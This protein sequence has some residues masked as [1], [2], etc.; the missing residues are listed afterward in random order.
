[1]FSAHKSQFY[2]KVSY[3]L[4][5]ILC[6]NILCTFLEDFS[7]NL[8]QLITFLAYN[9][10]FKH[11][12]LMCHPN[13]HGF[14]SGKPIGHSLVKACQ[15]YTDSFFFFFAIAKHFGNLLRLVQEVDIQF[16]EEVVLNLHEQNHVC[17][18]VKCR[19]SE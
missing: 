6:F 14:H 15:K 16:L 18:N 8:F 7:S 11:D 17:R 13:L 9:L 3:S 19:M 10:H 1:M 5:N 2:L 4:C 12:S